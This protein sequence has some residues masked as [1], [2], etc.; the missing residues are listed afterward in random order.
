MKTRCIIPFMAAFLLTFML[1][2]QSFNKA[3]LD[4]LLSLLEKK[5]KAMGSLAISRNGEI[6]YAK[7]IG[8][9]YLKLP[10]KI[11]ADTHTKYRIGSIT[12]MFTA[13][14]I[15]QL[16]EEGKLGLTTTLDEFFPS[17][18]GATSITIGQ[19]LGHRSGIS[20][21]TDDP[22]YSQ[23]MDKPKTHEE[24]IEIIAA[25]KPV[26]EPGSQAAYSNSNYVLL[27]YIL[28]SVCNKSYNEILAERICSG[29]GL[30]DTYYGGSTDLSKN[31]SYSYRYT[32]IWEQLPETDMSIPHGAGGIVSTPSDLVR[33]ADALFSGRLVQESS[34]SAM[35]TINDNFGMG[36]F[37]F[38]FKDKKAFG[39]TGS[40]DGFAS[41]I[42]SFLDDGVTFAYTSNGTVYPMLEIFFGALSIYFNMPYDLPVF[43]S[44]YV[45][46]A[47]LDQYLGVYASTQIPLKITI[48]RNNFTLF[49]QA[50]GQPALP[51]QPVAE[52][53]FSL[54]MAGAVMKFD[55]ERHLFRLEQG[56]RH[57]VFTK[58]Q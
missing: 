50:T 42:G 38:P 51:L 20:S 25:G 10:Q 9:R 39:H 16:I 53:T 15:F 34:L 27:G 3:K 41:T 5:N 32:G 28:E 4:S 6:I 45:N 37:L 46:P 23:W 44:Y 35:K 11:E 21:F 7:A 40:I 13:T 30:T 24:I 48:T 18:P 31:E 14:L 8:Y 49:G 1:Q 52:H 17:I 26:F 19:L 29:I 33:F 36:L 12:K 58:E 47:D 54:E 55:P 56:G 2:G 57:F 22:A 43:T